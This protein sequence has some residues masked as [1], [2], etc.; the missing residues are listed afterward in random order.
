MAGIFMILEWF[1]CD[2]NSWSVNVKVTWQID[3]KLC[4]RQCLG[5]EQEKW[6]V[7]GK[8]MDVAGTKFV[9]FDTSSVTSREGDRGWMIRAWRQDDGSANWHKF[10]CRNLA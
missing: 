10:P 1:L 2:Y 4:L 3:Q 8:K 7:N 5:T 6:S 9:E